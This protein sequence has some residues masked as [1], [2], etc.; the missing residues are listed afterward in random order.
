MQLDFDFCL[1]YCNL[2]D[3]INQNS[4]GEKFSGCQ[5]SSTEKK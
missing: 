4:Y 2:F 3:T 5:G 1:K